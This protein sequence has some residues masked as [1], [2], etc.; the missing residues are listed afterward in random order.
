MYPID[1]TTCTAV[2]V[3]ERSLVCHPSLFRDRVMTAHDSHLLFAL[4]TKDH[5]AFKAARNAVNQTERVIGI[6]RKFEAS[7]RAAAEQIAKVGLGELVQAFHAAAELNCVPRS[8]RGAIIERTP[9]G[10]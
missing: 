1:F 9:H 10:N 5:A 2:D 4:G 3:I 8:L 6:A 7:P